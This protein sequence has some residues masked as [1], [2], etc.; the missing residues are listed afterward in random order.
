MN[1][2]NSLFEKQFQ[3]VTYSP[4]KIREINDQYGRSI[5]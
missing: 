3:N 1:P 2:A 4:G 5:T